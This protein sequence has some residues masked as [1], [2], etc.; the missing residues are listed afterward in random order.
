LVDDA[1]DVLLI[2][3]GNQLAGLERDLDLS[4]LVRLDCFGTLA[5][6]QA[7]NL[8]NLSQYVAQSSMSPQ[9][10][11]GVRVTKVTN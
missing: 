10:N 6:D 9:G 5:L 4:A 7:R 8:G 11:V 2:D 3:T 1:I